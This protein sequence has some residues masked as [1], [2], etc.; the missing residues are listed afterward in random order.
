MRPKIN[1]TPKIK[2]SSNLATTALL[3]AHLA[4]NTIQK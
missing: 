1:G 4:M 3:S 2:I